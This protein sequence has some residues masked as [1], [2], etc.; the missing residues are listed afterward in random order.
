MSMK[1]TPW[2]DA[3]IKPARAGEYECRF[4]WGTIRLLWT[5]AEWLYPDNNGPS[6]FA[7]HPGTNRHWRG[8]AKK[9]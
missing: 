6:G 7:L 3:S 8:L 4:V 2:F 1:R 5:G 9:P